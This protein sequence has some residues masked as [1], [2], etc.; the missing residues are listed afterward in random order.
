M[1][2]HGLKFVNQNDLDKSYFAYSG[3]NSYVCNG[4]ESIYN[5]LYQ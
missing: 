5:I 3:T 1:S 2:K 4:K